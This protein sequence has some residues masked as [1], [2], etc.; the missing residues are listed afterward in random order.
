MTD[1]TITRH[2]LAWPTGRS[3]TAIRARP[4]FTAGSFAG[5]RDRLLAELRM[6]HA[7]GVILSTNVE[8]RRDGLPLAGQRNPADPGVAVYFRRKD[9]DLCFVCDRWATVESN[10]RAVSD[11]I[12]AIRLIERRGT[13]EMVDQAFS[14][15]AALPSGP[16]PVRSMPTGSRPWWDVLGMPAHTPTNDVTERYRRLVMDHHPD[17][18]GDPAK[19]VE[20]NTAFDRFKKERGL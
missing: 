15:F 4:K 7:S 16:V 1:D 2:P 19:M 12:D 5:V 8:L 18:G 10:M 20:I 9:R 17:R 14:G 3:R 6:L 11:A 13:G